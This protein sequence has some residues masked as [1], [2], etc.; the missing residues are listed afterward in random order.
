MFTFS[1]YVSAIRVTWSSKYE[2]SAE[3]LNSLF[4]T[5]LAEKLDIKVTH[6]CAN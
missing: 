2:Y 5:Q 3:L 6:I 4:P 1:L